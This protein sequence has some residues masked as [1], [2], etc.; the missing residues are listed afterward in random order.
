M[1]N[2]VFIYEDDDTTAILYNLALGKYFDITFVGTFSN[3]VYTLDNSPEFDC[4]IIDLFDKT[5]KY[6]GADL[7]PLINSKKIIFVTALDM[8]FQMSEKYKDLHYIRKP[9]FNY[10]EFIELINNVING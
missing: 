2:R 10:G 3:A 1:R 6:N 8:S 7:I 9:I 5:S 4:Y